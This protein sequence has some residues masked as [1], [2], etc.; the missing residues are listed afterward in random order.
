MAGWRCAVSRSS[1]STGASPN[2]TGMSPGAQ[3]P[4]S[5]AL[6]RNLG[7]QPAHQ[8]HH[9][10]QLL[11]LCQQVYPLQQLKLFLVQDPKVT[12]CSLKCVPYLSTST[13]PVASDIFFLIC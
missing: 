12:W 10:R 9:W 1:A 6:H 11:Q 13:E 4:V 7:C 2:T 3:C 5:L 8:W